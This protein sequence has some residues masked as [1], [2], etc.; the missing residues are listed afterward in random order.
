MIKSTLIIGMVLFQNFTSLDFFGPYEVFSSFPNSKILLISKSLSPVKSEAGAQ[1]LPN[2]IFS[3]SPQLDL[4]FVPGGSGVNDVLGDKETLKF[5]KSQS[6]H[7]KY[8]VSVCT[9]ALILGACG[10]LQGY[11]ATT[12]W[13]S[14]EF[15]KEFGAIPVQQRFVV[16]RNRYTGGGVTA[17]ID[18]ALKVAHD[19]YGEDTAKSIQLMLEYNPKPEFKNAGSPVTAEQKIVKNVKE[20]MKI[21]FEK[22]KHAV[23]NA[24]KRMNEPESSL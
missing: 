3:K 1:V 23:L 7:A 17:G 19:L 5:I 14:L 13:D 8:I 11:Q 21:L 16:D 6:K 24:K 4:I 20:K 15:L 12:H 22:R 18:L 9:G 10:L 2:T